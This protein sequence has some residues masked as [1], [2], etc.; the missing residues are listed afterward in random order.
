MAPVGTAQSTASSSAG[1][2][3]GASV[4]ANSASSQPQLDDMIQVYGCF[5]SAVSTLRL[6]TVKEIFPL[7]GRR[8][9]ES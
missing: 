1:A 5:Q 4:A 2:N 3:T 8:H 7:T 6:D 9:R